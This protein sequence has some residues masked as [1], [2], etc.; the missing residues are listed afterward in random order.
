MKHRERIFM[1]MHICIQIKKSNNN[2]SVVICSNIKL[3]NKTRPHVNASLFKLTQ[4]AVL[5]LWLLPA[6]AA[7]IF[8][9]YVCVCVCMC[10]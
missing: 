1:F 3:L 6:V 9:A 10:R 8:C 5:L 4:N 7:D 2:N